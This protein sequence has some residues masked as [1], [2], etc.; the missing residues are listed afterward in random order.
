MKLELT[1]VRY[2]EVSC[3]I[4]EALATRTPPQKKGLDGGRG[5]VW[6]ILSG[7]E[8]AGVGRRERAC[9]LPPC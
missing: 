7:I 4:I 5:V 8:V 9:R 2:Q 1:L 6:L 3:D